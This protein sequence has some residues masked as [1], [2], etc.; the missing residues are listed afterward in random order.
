[1]LEYKY[2]ITLTS[3]CEAGSGFGSELINS[4]LPRNIDGNFIIPASHIKGVMRDLFEN[5]GENLFNISVKKV[6]S[7]LFGSSGCVNDD[8]QDAVFNL[9]DAQPEDLSKGIKPLLITRTALD[10][11]GI[12]IDHSLRTT[13][14]FPAGTILQGSLFVNA[15][16]DSL[17]DIAIK[18]AL[19]SVLTIGG[20]RNR[21]SGACIVSLDGAD[22]KSIGSLLKELVSKINTELETTI[23]YL[24][25][26]TAQSQVCS[27]EKDPIVFVKLLFKSDGK[28]CCPELP[29][30][31]N[32]VIKSGFSIPASA[33]QGVL[34]NLLNNYSEQLATDCF[35]HD[36]FRIWPLYP[37]NEDGVIPC[38]VS[39]THKISKLPL[40][41]LNDKH[42][43]LDLFISDYD[44]RTVAKGSPLKGC[45]GVLLHSDAGSKISLW[46]SSDMPRIVSAHG[47]HE[48]IDR[49]RNLFTVESIAVKKF[50]GFCS[51][52]KSAADILVNILGKNNFVA[53]GKNR[54]IRGGGRL[55]AEVKSIQELVP[56]PN[57]N[58]KNRLFITQS[59][60]AVEGID[61]QN[62]SAEDILSEIVTKSG[63]GT[64]EK[65]SATLTVLFGWNRHKIGKRVDSS[66]RLNSIPVIAPGSV[67]L[68]NEAI[69]DSKLADFLIKGL[70]V[71]KEQGLGALLPHPGEASER[72]QINNVC[73]EVKNKNDSALRAYKIAAKS[74]K[75]LS[76]SQ[77][78]A[79]L[80]QRM[81]GIE[82]SLNYLE[83]Q[84]LQRPDKIW[85]RWKPVFDDLKQELRKVD[86][87]QMLNVWQ[88]LAGANK[89]ED[90]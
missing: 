2:K 11:N 20:N 22:N 1:M 87:V 43:F 32:N 85:D 34:L 36:K 51:M 83:T 72:F 63:W 16:K 23:A 48:G 9:T 4:L 84:R 90:K 44:W 40:K 17:I 57:H 27:I 25:S 3:E 86:A 77:I 52:P 31:S 61:I 33:V 42:K 58:Y 79:L 41:E 13:E 62:K 5:I 66:N 46:R 55:S 59:P 75:L 18:F 50:A 67:F 73:I 71:G 29:L 78:S 76:R 60:I 26:K 65:K 35:N 49:E 30:V 81:I 10:E 47:V 74:E 64:V 8:G 38:R 7:L 6:S 21:G 89:E 24:K 69:P 53:F 68:L 12:A 28:I 19:K 37:T 45:D 88:D 80:T 15:E 82:Q 39:S 70:S 54:S 56:V 14:A